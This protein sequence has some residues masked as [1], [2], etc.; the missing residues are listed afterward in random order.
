MGNFLSGTLQLFRWQ[1][2]FHKTV[3]RSR[4]FNSYESIFEI[5]VSM[6]NF[7]L[8]TNTNQMMLIELFL[9]GTI[10]TVAANYIVHIALTMR[11]LYSSVL[12][13]IACIF[14]LFLEVFLLIRLFNLIKLCTLFNNYYTKMGM[15]NDGSDGSDTINTCQKQQLY[16]ILWLGVEFIT[17]LL[18]MLGIF[19]SW[20]AHAIVKKQIRKKKK[21][22]N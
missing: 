15:L 18:K 4:L 14:I 9:I 12:N 2:S 5:F 19:F 11:F 16:Y 8:F 17:I 1:K 7:S 21:K 20:K 10:I 13:V 22:K 3:N 6:V